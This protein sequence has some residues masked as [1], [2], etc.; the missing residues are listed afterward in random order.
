MDHHGVSV[1]LF[2]SIYEEFWI[3]KKISS[4][5]NFVEFDLL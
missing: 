1:W 5:E 2:H 3:I 4:G